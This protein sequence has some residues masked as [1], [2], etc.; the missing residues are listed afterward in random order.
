[1][2]ERDW[3]EFWDTWFECFFN[4]I[5]YPHLIYARFW[6]YILKIRSFKI[7]LCKA[8]SLWSMLCL[9]SSKIYILMKKNHQP[10]GWNFH[11][12][13]ESSAE[14]PWRT[15]YFLAIG[16][17]PEKSCKSGNIKAGLAYRRG[18]LFLR[19][20]F[21]GKRFV[22]TM[23][24]DERFSQRRLWFMSLQR[25]DEISI[26]NKDSLVWYAFHRAN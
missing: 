3:C 22:L 10:S 26:S 20:L 13:Y 9:R 4:V 1:M 8:V 14:N 18:R 5:S 6:I 15:H 16:I 24:Y 25:T 21:Q 19:K 23:R 12:R 11:K 2:R 7:E 17:Q